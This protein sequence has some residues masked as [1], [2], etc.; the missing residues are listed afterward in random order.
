MIKMSDV[1][2]EKFRRVKLNMEAIKKA[3]LGELLEFNEGRYTPMMVNTIVMLVE[4]LDEIIN[5]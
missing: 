2:L 3:R 4:V 1:S 5:E